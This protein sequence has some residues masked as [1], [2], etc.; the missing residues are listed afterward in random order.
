MVQKLLMDRF[1]LVI[2]REVKEMPVYVLMV[3]KGGPKI[4]KADIEEK[5]C[6]PST[7]L[8][9]RPGDPVEE[10]HV[11]LGG[12]GRGLHARA[13]D[14]S[15]LVRYVGN[16][17]DRPL[18]DQTGIKGL[19]RIET[20]GWLPLEPGPPPAPG[21]KSE[22]GTALADLPTLFELF[23]GLGLKMEANRGKAVVYVIDHIERPSDE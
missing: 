18:I 12:R 3:A 1:R 17:T 6:R 22:D 5:D 23:E 11:F 21:A 13:V 15:D 16:W 4:A 8:N 7:I 2:H 14:M 20:K 9:L 19:Y 10:C